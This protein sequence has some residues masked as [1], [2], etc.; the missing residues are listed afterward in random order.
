MIHGVILIRGVWP[1][2]AGWRP[3]HPDQ[4]VRGEERVL[5]WER[6]TEGRDPDEEDMNAYKIYSGKVGD[7]RLDPVRKREWA[8]WVRPFYQHA[9]R[10]RQNE[11]R[12]RQRELDDIE[13]RA[14]EDRD[15]QRRGGSQPAQRG[16]W[17]G[18]RGGWSQREDRGERRSDDRW[19]QGRDRRSQSS[20]GGDSWW[21]SRD[22]QWNQRGGRR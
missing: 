4:R 22:S 12:R 3:R 19:H 2:R 11:A 16:D 13:R 20:Y 7:K 17:Q 8:Y 6:S 9:E 15:A 5:P 1:N 14:R 18:S 21:Q 10:E